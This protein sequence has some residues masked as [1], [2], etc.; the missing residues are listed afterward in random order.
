MRKEKLATTIS[1]DPRYKQCNRRLLTGL[2][3]LNLVSVCLGLRP[4][5]E[6]SGGI[7]LCARVSAVVFY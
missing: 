4:R 2:G 6:A 5:P 7:Y 3:L 1:E